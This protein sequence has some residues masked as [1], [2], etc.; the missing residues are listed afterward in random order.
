MTER[1]ILTGGIDCSVPDGAT[2][3]VPPDGLRKI[4]DAIAGGAEAAIEI[5]G[6]VVIEFVME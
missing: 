3:R 2:I 1:I 5:S 4:V 6:N